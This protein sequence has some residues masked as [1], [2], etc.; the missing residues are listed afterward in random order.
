MIN[1]NTGIEIIIATM[2]AA[3]IKAAGVPLA[4]CSDDL[5]WIHAAKVSGGA[6]VT[7]GATAE[8][9]I[10]RLRANVEAELARIAPYLVD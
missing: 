8:E 3:D 2:V 6:G 1:I 7:P 9:L 10:A 4:A 5:L